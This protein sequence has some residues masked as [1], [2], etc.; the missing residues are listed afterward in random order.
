MPSGG[1]EAGWNETWAASL[2]HEWRS[3]LAGSHLGGPAGRGQI[4]ALVDRL[5]TLDRPIERRER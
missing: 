2:D 5:L 3:S 1:R 4:R